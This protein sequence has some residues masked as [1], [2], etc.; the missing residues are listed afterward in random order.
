MPGGQNRGHAAAEA[1]AWP[2]AGADRAASAAAI[3]ESLKTRAMDEASIGITVADATAADLPLVYANAA[4]ERI[5][6]YPPSYAIGRNCRFLQ[7]EGTRAAPVERMREAIERGAAT[8][9]ELRNYRRDGTRFWNEVT[10][11]PLCDGD[12]DVAYYVGFQRDVTQRK[13][14]ERAAARRAARIEAE[15][16]TQERLLERLDGVVADVTEAV[17]RARSRTDLACGVVASLESTYAGAWMGTYDPAAE[18]VEPRVVAG[19][20]GGDVPDRAV[21]VEAGETSVESAVSAALRDRC[22]RIEPLPSAT[23]GATAV[24][25]IP[26]RFGD[27]CYGVICVYARTLEDVVDHEREVLAAMGRTVA[28]GINALERSRTLREDETVEL[29]FGLRGS[30]PLVE[31]AARLDCRLEFAG[32]VGDRDRPTHLYEVDVEGSRVRSAVEGVAVDL[33]AVL[34][35]GTADCLVELSVRDSP[36][37]SL[38]AEHG[39][40]LQAATFRPTGGEVTVTVGRESL[41]R[42]LADAVGERFER[43]ELHRYRRRA[44]RAVPRREFVAELAAEL[45]DRQH[46]AL[47]RAHTGG[48]FEWPRDATGEDVAAAMGVCRSTFHQHLRAALRK[49]V[50]AVVEGD[51]GDDPALDTGPN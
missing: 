43:G 25:A 19:V 7:G 45:T 51:V 3:D 42:S 33:H 50:G 16:A 15:R 40:A 12:G 27:V 26:I 14:A 44:D 22:V 1:D 35:E 5:T 18:A 34:V 23:G 47:V 11:A 30:H 39:A 20:P 31:L 38:L 29:G 8:S 37:R 28:T 41:A 49:V 9:V 17:M 13:R 6:G 48:Y 2:G 46:A 36:L 24:A 10:I 32:R 21:S 4:F